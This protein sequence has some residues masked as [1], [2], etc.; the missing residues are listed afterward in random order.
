MAKAS[1]KK[2][3]HK[4]RKKPGPRPL[5][6]RAA[7]SKAKVKPTKFK[8]KRHSAVAE[9]LRKDGYLRATEVARR[10]SMHHSAVYRMLDREEVEG[11]RVA[12]SRYVKV[13]SLKKY[14]GEAAPR[15]DLSL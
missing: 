15:F 13:A 2:M 6:E 11:L 7:R 10:L 3:G 1:S 9:K 8:P 4:P 12:G 5:N 14:L